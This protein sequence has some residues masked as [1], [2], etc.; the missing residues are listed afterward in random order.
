MSKRAKPSPP[1]QPAS[2]RLQVAGEAGV[3]LLAQGRSRSGHASGCLALPLVGRD[4]GGRSVLRAEQG[5]AQRSEDGYR[6]SR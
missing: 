2:R 5:A 6:Q 4:I 3:A 1:I